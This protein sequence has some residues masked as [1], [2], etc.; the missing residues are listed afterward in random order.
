MDKEQ[1]KA[2]DIEYQRQNVKRI[3]FDLNLSTDKDILDHLATKTNRNGYIKALIR[4]DIE[5]ER[6]G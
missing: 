2:Y 3:P 5:K 6:N 4:A 1:K